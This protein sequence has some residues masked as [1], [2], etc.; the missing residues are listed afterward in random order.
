[1]TLPK[2]VTLSDEEQ[3]LIEHWRMNVALR[4]PELQFLLMKSILSMLDEEGL[5]SELTRLVDVPSL[6]SSHIIY[7]F[8]YENKT[9]FD[10][11]VENKSIDKVI[12][13]KPFYLEG[14]KIFYTSTIQEALDGYVQNDSSVPIETK[15][16]GTWGNSLCPNCKHHVGLYNGIFEFGQKTFAQYIC[17]DCKICYFESRSDEPFVSAGEKT[18]GSQKFS[19]IKL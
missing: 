3:G 12:L 6:G 8:E 16:H 11:E 5:N 1:M 9:R 13:L 14:S 19:K 17:S 7:G 15:D 4:I 18:K 2:V 10:I